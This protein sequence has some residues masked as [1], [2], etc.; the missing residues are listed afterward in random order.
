MQC[1]L[2]DP[3]AQRRNQELS[4]LELQRIRIAKTGRGDWGVQVLDNLPK[5]R[6]VLHYAGEAI[7]EWTAADR[8]A[9]HKESDTGTGVGGAVSRSSLQWQSALLRNSGWGERPLNLS[10]ASRH[11]SR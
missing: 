6:T 9:Y 4:R 10:S 3:L 8:I 5:G 11:G 7:T 2:N 1:P